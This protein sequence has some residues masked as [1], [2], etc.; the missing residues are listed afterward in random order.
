MYKPF[1]NFRFRPFWETPGEGAP[2]PGTSI[3]PADDSVPAEETPPV[4]GDEETPSETAPSDDDKSTDPKSAEPPAPI[5]MEDITLPEGVAIPEE[6]QT[7]LL[8]VLNDNEL[9]RGE[10]VS[11]LISMQAEA[12]ATAQES[13]WA[14]TQTQWREQT[15]ALPNFGGDKLEQNL[16]EIKRGLD[17]AGATKEAYEAL[18]V[19]GLGNNPHILPLLHKLAQPFLEGTPVTGKP[20]QGNVDRAAVLYPTMTKE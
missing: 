7:A 3:P 11:K 18:E 10:L 5:T 8:E 17:A 9:S 12:T 4:E 6:S 19:T 2:T 15:A 16:A 14:E 20:S 13:A 1:L